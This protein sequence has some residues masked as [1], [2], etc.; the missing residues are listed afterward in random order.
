MIRRPARSALYPLHDALRI[1]RDPTRPRPGRPE[2]A[3]GAREPPKTPWR[4][5][6]PRR[7]LSRLS[8]PQLAGGGPHPGTPRGAA[9]TDPHAPPPTGR[10]G[11]WEEERA[12][13]ADLQSVVEGKSVDLGGRPIIQTKPAQG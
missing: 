12:R 7:E 10:R 1:S 3:C 4:P 2:P 13:G 6:A 9:A 5:R 8:L 11:T